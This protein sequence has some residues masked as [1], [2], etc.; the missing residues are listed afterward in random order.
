MFVFYITTSVVTH[1]RI[2]VQVTGNFKSV[3]RFDLNGLRVS[4]LGNC[5]WRLELRWRVLRC[6]NDT[7]NNRT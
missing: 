5:G 6:S 7:Y 1:H 2:M 4:F 3:F